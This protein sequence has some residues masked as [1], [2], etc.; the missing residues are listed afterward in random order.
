MCWVCQM[1][2][3]DGMEMIRRMRCSADTTPVVVCAADVSDAVRAAGKAL[4]VAAF[5]VKP[6]SPEQFIEQLTAAANRTPVAL[7]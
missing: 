2:F 7:A 4:G 6:V 3:L 1:P 5:L